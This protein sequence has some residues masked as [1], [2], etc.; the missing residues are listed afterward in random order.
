MRRRELHARRAG[1][2]SRRRRTARRAAWRSR[3]RRAGRAPDAATPRTSASPATA[4][5]IWR[6]VDA[7]RSQQRELARALGDGD[8]EGVEDDERAD[9]QRGA[10]EREQHRRQEAAD[11]VVDVVGRLLGVGCA[12]LDLEVGGGDLADAR[13]ERLGR[14]AVL[15]GGDGRS[16]PRPSRSNHSCTCGSVAVTTVAPP[17]E[18]TS[19]YSKM[20]TIVTCLTPVRVARPTRWPTRRSSFSAVWLMTPTSPGP[21]G[22]RPATGVVGS[23]GGAHGR[24]HRARR[25]VAGDPLAADDERAAVPQLPG[26]LRDAGDL[27]DA[28]DQRLRQRPAGRPCGA[29]LLLGTDHGVGALVGGLLDVLERRA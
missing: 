24:H 5:T 22:C 2:R 3:A 21:A 23:N 16:S 18:A 6:R 12:G 8:R 13:G 27:R 7:E 26:G 9:Q 15:G 10:G 28:C 19:P 29:E 11:R 4:A 1:C 17:T 14:H 20:P 25:V